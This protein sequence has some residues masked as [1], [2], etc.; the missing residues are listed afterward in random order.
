MLGMP[1]KAVLKDFIDCVRAMIPTVE[2]CK[3]LST[4]PFPLTP[5]RYPLTHYP[6]LI[7][8]HLFP[9]LKSIIRPHTHLHSLRLHRK[10][11]YLYT[12]MRGFSRR[13]TIFPRLVSFV[14]ENDAT[15]KYRVFG[16]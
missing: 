10:K 8:H 6:P 7:I 14:L 12:P 3:L 2:L 15:H 16:L 1:A 5:I 11:L 9:K 4:V 13:L